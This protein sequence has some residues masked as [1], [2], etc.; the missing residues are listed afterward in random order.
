MFQRYSTSWEL[1][2]ASAAVLRSDKHLIVFPL[3]SFLAVVLVTITFAVPAF[4]AGLFDGAIQHGS[5]EVQVHPLGYVLGFLFY[6]TQYFVIFFANAAL[7]GAAMIRLR[8]GA[9]TLRDGFGIAMS[10][11]GSI[12]GYALIAATVGVVLRTLSERAGILG[13][14]VVS[15]I[16]LAWN[17]ATYL[18]V[19]VLITEKAGP[20]GSVK[21]SSELLKRTW[22]E[23][24]VG[25]ASISLITG[26]ILLGIF[27]LGIPLIVFAAM[28][29]STALIVAS[30]AFT[31][32]ALATLA[33][34]SAALGGIYT[35]AI[36]RYAAEG[37]SDGFF[38]PELV[39]DAFRPKKKK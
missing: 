39:R 11:V 19:P 3:V 28:S 33:L 14:I 26:L 36:Y 13:R 4:L 6:L 38:R 34:V 10:H 32:L 2:K 5:S 30:L 18:V 8:G 31:G 7:I 9:P 27:L 22:G 21:R 35:A 12:F 16:G 37:A 1:V 24:I 25:N 15:L 23:Q 17:V 29:Q 20:I